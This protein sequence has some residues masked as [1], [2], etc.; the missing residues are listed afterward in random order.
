[1]N[2]FN[3]IFNDTYIHQQ[4]T[5]AHEQQIE[6]VLN[7]AHKLKEFLDSTEDIKPEYRQ[8]ASIAFCSI[9]ADYLKKHGQL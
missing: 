1:M 6:N 8:E 3:Q 5:R 7:S 2:P 9:L 4:A